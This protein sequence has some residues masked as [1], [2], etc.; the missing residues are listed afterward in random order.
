[1][2]DELRQALNQFLVM[3]KAGESGGFRGLVEEGIIAG[4]F[5]ALNPGH[6][7]MLLE[8]KERVFLYTLHFRWDADDIICRKDFTPVTQSYC[9]WKFFFLENPPEMPCN[10][11]EFSSTVVL[12]I[13]M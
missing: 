3:R 2:S 8:L 4:G 5:S 7:C 12:G 11:G 9:K 1:M 13:G 10:S 6:S